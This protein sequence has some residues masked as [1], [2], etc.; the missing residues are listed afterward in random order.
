MGGEGVDDTSLSEGF[1]GLLWYHMKRYKFDKITF[2]KDL[3][4]QGYFIQGE[5]SDGLKTALET[6]GKT[7]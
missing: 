5:G 4:T 3:K 7:A 2:F 6:R 1:S